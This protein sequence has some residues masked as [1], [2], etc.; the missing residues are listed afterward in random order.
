M[1]KWIKDAASVQI[2]IEHYNLD[3]ES[4]FSICE[5]FFFTLV[6]DILEFVPS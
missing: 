3:H 4:S 6:G 2:F 5:F 1:E